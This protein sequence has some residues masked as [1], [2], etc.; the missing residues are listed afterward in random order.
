MSSKLGIFL[1]SIYGLISVAVLGYVMLCSSMFCGLIILV[2]ILPWPLLAE[3]V[4]FPTFL[5]SMLGAIIF[6]FINTA[7]LYWIGATI[8]R[9][10]AKK[11]AIKI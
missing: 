9:Y 8:E 1:A 10:R 11:S 7:L 3:I 4:G 2:P 5:D 6:M